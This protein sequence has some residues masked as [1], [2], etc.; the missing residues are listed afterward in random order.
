MLGWILL[1]AFIGGVVIA[2]TVDAVQDKMREE[3]VRKS[4]VTA[5]NKSKNR[6]KFRDLENWEEYEMEGEVSDEIYEG[7]I[8]YA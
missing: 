5:V 1:G 7:Q 8:I 4:I 2:I 6:I 3:G